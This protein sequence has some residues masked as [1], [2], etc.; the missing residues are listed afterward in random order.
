MIESEK[1]RKT[2]VLFTK[3]L[4]IMDLKPKDIL[5]TKDG[6]LIG[7]AIVLQYPRKGRVLIKTDYGRAVI[8]EMSQ[9][10]ELF[11]KTTGVMPP[12]QP[13]KYEKECT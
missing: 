3:T 2:K 7:N 10:Q 8:V 5:F 6:R 1:L 13:H 11:Y 9:I 12:F 4:L